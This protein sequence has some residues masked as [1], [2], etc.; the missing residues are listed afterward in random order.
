[1]FS[2]QVNVCWGRN[3]AAD[4]TEALTSELGFL[5]DRKRAGYDIFVI[6]E[7]HF[8]AGDPADLSRHPVLDFISH[9]ERP[10]R[11]DLRR[12]AKVNGLK[13]NFVEVPASVPPVPGPVINQRQMKEPLPSLPVKVRA[14]S[15][16]GGY[17]PLAI[18]QQ[19]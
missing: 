11:T 19:E 2:S 17:I 3:P 6:N 10:Q 14:V 13:K 7:S 1:M 4:I 5:T 15:M 9:C 12:R 18:R 16:Q 8:T